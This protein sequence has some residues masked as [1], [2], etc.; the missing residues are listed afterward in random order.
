MINDDTKL[1]LVSRNPVYINDDGN[2]SIIQNQYGDDE[3]IY[4]IS[5]SGHLQ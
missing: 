3:S 1:L 4:S 2:T 5:P